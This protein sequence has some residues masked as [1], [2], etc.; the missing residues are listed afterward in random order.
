M[1]FQWPQGQRTVLSNHHG[2]EI[3]GVKRHGQTLK[4]Q[5]QGL[6]LARISEVW[7]G[8]HPMGDEKPTWGKTVAETENPPDPD[9]HEPL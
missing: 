2:G 9:D 4:D 7:P 5:F 3:L 6:V 8:P 1:P